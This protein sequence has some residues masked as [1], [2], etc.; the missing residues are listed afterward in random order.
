MSSVL[1]LMTSKRMLQLPLLVDVSRHSGVLCITVMRSER[2]LHN[3]PLCR[4]ASTFSHLDWEACTT[5]GAVAQLA[6]LAAAPGVHLTTTSQQ[7]SMVGA[8]RNLQHSPQTRTVSKPG[9]VGMG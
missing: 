9:V 8:N 6:A 1:H 2:A 4:L 7:G 3:T 5:V